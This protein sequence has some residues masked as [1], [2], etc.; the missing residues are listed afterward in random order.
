MTLALDSL[1]QAL[2]YATTS[3]IQGKFWDPGGEIRAQIKSGIALASAREP[4]RPQIIATAEWVGQKIEEEAD[5]ARRDE[6]EEYRRRQS[7]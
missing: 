3:T 1:I 2:D 4:D 5:R 7:R 6:T